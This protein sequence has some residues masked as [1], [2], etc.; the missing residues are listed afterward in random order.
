MATFYFFQ[1]SRLLYELAL[2]AQAVESKV[3]PRVRRRELVFLHCPTPRRGGHAL[4]KEL[5]GGTTPFAAPPTEMPCV[6]PP[7][8]P[9]A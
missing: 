5:S 8:S 2:V 9:Q 6:S 7:S 4:T 1:K 3:I